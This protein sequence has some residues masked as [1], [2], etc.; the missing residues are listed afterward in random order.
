M[1]CTIIILCLF[2]ANLTVSACKHGE[3][4]ESKYNFWVE[5]VSTII[6][7]LLYW[8]AGLFDKFIK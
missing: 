7:L 5:L 4:R 6:L 8:G 3:F 1:I 2:A